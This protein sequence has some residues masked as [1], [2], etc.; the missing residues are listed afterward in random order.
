MAGKVTDALTEASVFDQSLQIK[1]T[2]S[3]SGIDFYRS[4]IQQPKTFKKKPLRLWGANGLKS[5]SQR[6]RRRNPAAQYYKNG[7]APQSCFL[8]GLISFAEHGLWVVKPL[9]TTCFFSL[10]LAFGLAFLHFGGALNRKSAGRYG[11]QGDDSSVPRRSAARYLG[12]RN[13]MELSTQ[14]RQEIN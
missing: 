12:W 13:T 10:R 1:R 6:R 8:I 5:G 3:H 4:T 14:K 7:T 2:S 11:A 9:A